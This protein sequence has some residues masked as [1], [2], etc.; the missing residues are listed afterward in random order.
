[1]LGW[2][3]VRLAGSVL[4]AALTTLAM[5]ACS[6]QN[7]PP[8]SRA[9][10]ENAGSV[11]LQL[12][13]SSG[14][15]INV[16]SYTITGPGGYSQTGN[17]DVSNSPI[18]SAVIGGIPAGTGYTIVLT[19]TAV[20]GGISTCMG[21]ATFDV[22]ANTTVTVPVTVRCKKPLRF[23]SVLINGSVNECP[24][25]DS[26]G[27]LPAKAAIGGTMSLTST[28]S[29]GDS[30]TLTY[31]WTATSGT[32][33]G[34]SS[35][36]ATFTC[37]EVGMP[38]IT[39]TVS[40][41]DTVCDDVFP[42]K[43]ICVACLG[44]GACDDQNACTLGDTCQN[45]SCKAT[46]F[47]PARTPC[48][49]S[50]ICDGAG[51]CV[52]CLAPSD[53]PGSD[54]ACRMRTCTAGV[55]GAVNAPAGPA[56]LQ[57]A[58]DCKQNRCDGVGN[59]FV[60]ND[61]TDVPVDGNQCTNDVCTSGVPSNPP[62]AYGTSCTQSG[63]QIC[64][65]DGSC[66]PITFNVVRVG[67]GS[68]ALTADSTA[69]VIERHKLDGSLVGSPIA[70]PTAVNGANRPLTNTGLAQDE[71]MLSRSVDGHSLSMLGYAAV[72]GIG[73]PSTDATIARVVGRIDAAGNVDTT[74]VFGLNGFSGA[75]A[76]TATSLDGTSFWAG[77]GDGFAG[78]TGASLGGIWYIPRGSAGGGVQL[79]TAPARVL[80]IFGG[81]LLGTGDATLHLEV[82]KV[83]NGLPTSGS[84]SVTGLA[85]MLT[86]G[87][88][89]WGFVFF[90]L[91]SGVGDPTLG[92]L[93]D[94][95]FV[96]SSQVGPTNGIQRWTYNSGS[97]QWSLVK[98]MNVVPA[99]SFRGL[100]GLV[101]GSNVTL[102]A[103]T[104]GTATN[105]VAVFVDD[106]S[107]NP[108]GTNILTGSSSLVYRGVALPPFN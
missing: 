32:I 60:A 81:Q 105:R 40:D 4:V 86:S 92:G 7:A 43:V 68:T 77:G 65:G 58:G 15:Q 17:I 88:N 39:L 70:L 80:G 82:Y 35:P 95:V 54:T 48:A 61:D 13:L 107:P 78:P 14:E 49:P 84:P 27:I 26:A 104:M 89:P 1:V 9:T 11:G 57:T 72:P 108:V 52:E 67:N 44:S 12:T 29:D 5:G 106:G 76:R 71:G 63:G 45:E 91:V 87:V 25:I 42:M 21:S 47:A 41:G 30:P 83:G 8:S 99:V 79:S 56:P 20:D 102:I 10:V 74:T 6:G 38:T 100:T 36:N 62:S 50:K 103:S 3:L 97:A 73:D 18:F 2:K 22:V 28:A 69:V 31:S 23:G 33:A 34:A 64:S 16:L 98:T 90:D 55:C 94:T 46:S 59:F 24:N 37:T 51:A 75:V 101:T 19:A 96:V 66:V 85:G 93:V 53:C